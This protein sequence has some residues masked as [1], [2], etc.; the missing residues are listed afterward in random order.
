M[1]SSSDLNLNTTLKVAR[2][3]EANDNI[4]KAIEKYEKAINLLRNK[5]DSEQVLA[6]KEHVASLHQA[7]GNYGQAIASYEEIE[8]IKNHRR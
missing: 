8:N 6:L 2:N 7:S 4:P 3:Y 5:G 1:A